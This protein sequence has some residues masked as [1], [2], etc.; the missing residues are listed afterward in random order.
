M[1]RKS[2][3]LLLLATA[4]AMPNINHAAPAQPAQG[5]VCAGQPGEVQ[6]VNCIPA[7]LLKSQPACRQAGEDVEGKNRTFGERC[8][9]GLEPIPADRL[10][11]GQCQHAPPSVQTCAHCGDKI[12]GPGE[13]QCN[14]PGD[15]AA[16]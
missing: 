10:E 5:R 2:F 12:C 14:C 7:A 3:W 16:K 6:G 8:C 4:A 1:T 13:N 11:N 9:E 15:C